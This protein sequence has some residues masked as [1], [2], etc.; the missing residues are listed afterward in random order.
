MRPL[1]LQQLLGAGVLCGRV[2]QKL[3]GA[4]LR[5]HYDLLLVI[6]R[7]IIEDVR[8]AAARLRNLRQRRDQGHQNES[9]W[10]SV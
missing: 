5:A 3:Q 2:A 1:G 9:L 4:D 8:T 7:E 6:H 10:K